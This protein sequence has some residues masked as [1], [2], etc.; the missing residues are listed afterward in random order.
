MVKGWCAYFD[1]CMRGL[2]DGAATEINR[3]TPHEAV[4]VNALLSAFE[5]AVFVTGGKTRTPKRLAA[6]DMKM[7]HSPL[8]S[9]AL[10]SLS[11]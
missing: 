2:G 4:D 8:V 6:D 10:D 11:P 1:G 3:S 7:V 5:R 9:S